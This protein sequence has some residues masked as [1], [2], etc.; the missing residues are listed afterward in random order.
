MHGLFILICIFSE[1][2]SEVLAYALGIDLGICLRV[3]CIFVFCFSIHLVILT[4]KEFT[5]KRA[6]NT[7]WISFFV[8]LLILLSMYIFY[9]AHDFHHRI[10]RGMILSFG[11]KVIVAPFMA[12]SWN[13]RNFIKE[14]LYGIIPFVCF[15]TAFSYHA[16]VKLES[17]FYTELAICYQSLSYA[18]AYSIGLLFFFI[19]NYNQK[20]K[21]LN[22][23]LFILIVVNLYILFSGGGK[24]AFVLICVLFVCFFYNILKKKVVFL[25]IGIVF[26]CV[27]GEQTIVNYVG[28]FVGG[29]RILALFLSNNV[30]YVTSGRNA[31]YIKG[32]N[33]LFDRYFLGGGPG[34]VLYDIGY[35]SH[36]IFLDIL[37]DWGFVFFF[38][39]LFI[40]F[41]V[42]KKCFKNWHDVSISFLFL[43]FLGQFI[44]LFFSGSFYESFGLWFSIIAILMYEKNENRCPVVQSKS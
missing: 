2:F 43:I 33:T 36:N 21:W 15:F 24:G 7:F 30:E 31:L 26:L 35:F 28:Q 14:I 1:L 4:R 39:C 29:D 41:I 20:Q 32:I 25:L 38:L 23:L 17:Q 10:H 42:L 13:K 11:S 37:I 27:W 3:L 16:V 40:I 18:A 44:M 34:S 6:L 22:F 12:L 5:S 19:N 8:V 9:T